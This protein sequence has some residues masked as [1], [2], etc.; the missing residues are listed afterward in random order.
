MKVFDTEPRL[1]I[2]TRDADFLSGP[3]LRRILILALVLG[4][5]ALIASGARFD[6]DGG[7]LTRLL[8][9]WWTW[10]EAFALSFATLFA[11]FAYLQHK[12][13]L[14]KISDEVALKPIRRHLFAAHF[15]AIGIFGAL[16]AGLYRGQFSPDFVATGWLVAGLAAIG[17]A[18]FAVMPWDVWVRLVRGTW[19]WWVYAPAAAMAA[20][21]A[22]ALSGALS[23]PATR[24]TFNLVERWLSPL[25]SDLVLDPAGMIIG[26]HRFTA[27]ILPGCS[28]LEGAVF[29]LVFGVIYLV[30]FREELRF[31]QA[32]LLLPAGIALLFLLNA[33]RIVGLILIGD[34]GARGIAAGGF[35]E[36]AGWILFT[37]VAFG[38]AV[39]ARR[40]AWI[41]AGAPR[42]E[43]L[44]ESAGN[45]TLAYLT[46][47]LVILAAGMI[48]KAA[49]ANF[50]EWPLMGC[51]SWPL[52]ALYGCFGESMRSSTGSRD[53]TRRSAG[54]ELLSYGSPST[55]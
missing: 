29:M 8:R 13:A 19:K 4:S 34:A 16:T 27:R 14:A 45:P 48:S 20:F 44:E 39:V 37:L 35:H 12:T 47:L 50:G 33:A 26:T 25:V 24:L 41:S 22:S 51:V 40:V 17:V 2:E 38:L 31:P 42:P 11:T 28:G 49:S 1:E 9:D 6:S 46:P 5:E 54:W 18:G 32:F 15:A 10:V 30:L 36:Q 53:G 21:L 43:E 52:W 3:P 23:G 55:G 7:I